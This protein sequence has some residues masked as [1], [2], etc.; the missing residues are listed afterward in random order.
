MSDE[1]A[2]R[3][4][5]VAV[6]ELDTVVRTSGRS[7][8]TS[9]RAEPV[10]DL[11]AGKSSTSRQTREDARVPTPS[12]VQRSRGYRGRGN[13]RTGSARDPRARP[14]SN[15]ARHANAAAV[16]SRGQRGIRRPFACASK[17]TA[18]G[19]RPIFETP[20][21]VSSTCVPAP[22]ATAARVAGLGS[23]GHA[24]RHPDRVGGSSR[25]RARVTCRGRQ[26]R[27]M[28]RPVTRSVDTAITWLCPFGAQWGSGR[29][30]TRRSSAS[31]RISRA[32]PVTQTL[33]PPCSSGS[34]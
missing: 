26:G 25:G 8:S 3:R 17:M 9:R 12:D 1:E 5:E 19:C 30:A 13:G 18:T 24:A 20:V 22:S 28:R 29:C 11:S 7:S 32:T 31:S 4:I 14:S 27:G 2:R 21:T 16:R 15:V 34:M 33:H 23:V 10:P 6:D